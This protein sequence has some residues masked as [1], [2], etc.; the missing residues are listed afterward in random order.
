[1]RRP[2]MIGVAREAWPSAAS[3]LAYLRSDDSA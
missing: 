1:V 2:K 3:A